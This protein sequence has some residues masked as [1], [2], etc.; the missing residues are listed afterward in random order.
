MLL[1]L[2]AILDC[3]DCRTLTRRIIMSGL[4]FCVAAYLLG[5]SPATLQISDNL[6]FIAYFLGA[7]SMIFI[8]LFGLLVF[9]D[10][11][12]VQRRHIILGALYVLP[13][14]IMCGIE[15]YKSINPPSIWMIGLNIYGIILMAHLGYK[16]LSGYQNDLVVKRR[17]IRFLFI[18]AL[19]SVGTMTSLAHM[20][21]LPF[22]AA[23]ISWF[24]T[25][26][27]F[28]MTVWAFLWL[29]RVDEDQLMFRP[30]TPL[31]T[32]AAPTLEN[33]QDLSLI[34]I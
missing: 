13:A 17:R 7:P 8:W 34:H 25:I 14:L 11:F 6:R 28:V 3:R 29:T 30:A 5:K 4:C 10:D 32:L 1:F 23:T 12:R 26:A 24:E 21:A 16:I 22:S 20:Q 19:L 9:E 2:L 31:P 15:G 18:G 27:I 33:P